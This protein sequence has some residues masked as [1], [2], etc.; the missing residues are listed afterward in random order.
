MSENHE[1]L[2]IYHYDEQKNQMRM[3]VKWI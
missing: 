2:A 3:S 1:V